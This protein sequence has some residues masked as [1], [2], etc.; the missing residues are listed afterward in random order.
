MKKNSLI[1]IIMIL[2]MGLSIM[3]SSCF[4]TPDNLEGYIKSNSEVLDQIESAASAQGMTVNVK[5][6]DIS[7]VYD[8]SAA[9]GVTEESIK[10]S[11]V[12]EGLTKVLEDGKDKFIESCKELESTTGLSGIS[13]TVSFEY[14]GEQIAS[15]TY[16]SAD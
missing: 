1:A 15:Q 13:I 10:D 9:N 8:L 5:G 6:N 2:T 3:L 4:K 11:V 16:S 14:N 7:Y 12:Q